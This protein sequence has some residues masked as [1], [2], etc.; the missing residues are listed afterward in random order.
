MKISVSEKISA[1]SHGATVPV[2]TV[3]MF[4][5]M[6][7]SWGSFG[8][9]SSALIY[10]LSAIFLFSA[11]FLYHS[12]KQ[13]DNDKSMWR[14][15]D[16]TAIFFL[17]A[18]TYTP[19]CFLYL[20]GKMKWGIL[21]AQWILVILG[22]VFKFIFINAPRIMSTLVYLFMGWIVVIP[23]ATLVHVMEPAALKLLIAGGLSYTCGA[24]IYAFKKPD[25]L[26]GFFSFHEIFHIF[27]TTGA[28]L[29]LL[30]ILHGYK[31]MFYC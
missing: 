9:L 4:V 24:L 6:F 26:P 3:G 18:G 10:G 22:T 8:G 15:L 11:S 17:I 27:V 30:M 29:H 14:K 23:L 16:H 7:L 25:P 28:V 13:T 19:V 21:I 31:E 2:M 5:L 12:K 20:D 1:W